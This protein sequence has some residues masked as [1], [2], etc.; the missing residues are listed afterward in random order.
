[1]NPPHLMDIIEGILAFRDYHREL[2]ARHARHLQTRA[3]RSLTLN[4]L[5]TR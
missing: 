5:I 2:R 4:H 3:V 1:M